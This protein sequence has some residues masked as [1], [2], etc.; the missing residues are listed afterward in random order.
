MTDQLLGSYLW[1]AI[2]DIK[3]SFS[4]MPGMYVK[5]IEMNVRGTRIQS[6][7]CVGLIFEEFSE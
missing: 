6:S 3:T 1:A 7:I 4:N 5:V 2:V